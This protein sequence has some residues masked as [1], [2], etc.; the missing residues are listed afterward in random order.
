MFFDIN[1]LIFMIPAFILMGITSWYVRHAYN[2]WSQIRASSGLTGVDA[3]RRLISMNGLTGLKIQGTPGDLT[4]HY[5]PR[6]NTVYLSNGVANVPSVAALA[7]AAHELGHAQQD[8]EEYFPM[9]L[10]G[11]LVPMVNIGSNLGWILI[12][13]GL[14]LNFTGLAWLGVIIF[15]GGALFALATLPVEFDASARAK[16]MLANSGIIQTDEEMRGVSNVLNAAALTYVAGLV[17]AILQLLYYVS[18]VSGR[19][20]D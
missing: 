4:D 10:R 3:T 7:I 8:A 6:D 15:S 18:L 20:R 9:R 1:Y 11:F 2:K 19:S 16:R 12:L 17:T 5:D 13:A 14:L